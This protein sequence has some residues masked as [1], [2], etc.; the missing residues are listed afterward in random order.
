MWCLR[1]VS[2]MNLPLKFYARINSWWVAWSILCQEKL[3]DLSYWNINFGSLN[4]AYPRVDIKIPLDLN[5]CIFSYPFEGVSKVV[6]MCDVETFNT[7]GSK[8][9]FTCDFARIFDHFTATVH[10]NHEHTAMNLEAP[11]NPQIDRFAALLLVS[12]GVFQAITI[13]YH[14]DLS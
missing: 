12:C 10:W 1:E 8:G 5:K 13:V 4:M 14:S 6:S 3:L 9:A 2:A 7:K 11:P